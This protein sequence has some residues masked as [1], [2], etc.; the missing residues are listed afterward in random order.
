MVES[1]PGNCVDTEITFL[2]DP[3]VVAISPVIMCLSVTRAAPL[4]YQ[5]AGEQVETTHVLR[6]AAKSCYPVQLQ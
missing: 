6:H 1:I 5:T 3:Q 2:R 4:A